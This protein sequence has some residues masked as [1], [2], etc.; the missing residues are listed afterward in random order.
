MKIKTLR[1]KGKENTFDVD[2]NPPIETQCYKLMSHLGSLV[3]TVRLAAES[4]T[5]VLNVSI[6]PTQS[7]L[8][9]GRQ[10]Y[11][12]EWL[13]EEENCWVI[14]DVFPIHN[15]GEWLPENVLNGYREGCGE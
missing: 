11:H 8:V 3:H 7:W 10:L 14:T 9:V 1:L 4:E 5:T 6:D 15:P 13:E 12:I 2:V